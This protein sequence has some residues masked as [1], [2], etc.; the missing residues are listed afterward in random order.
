MSTLWEMATTIREEKSVRFARP[1]PA[2]NGQAAVV[3]LDE[4]SR[5]DYWCRLLGTTPWRLC[6]A[7]DHVG[8]DPTAIRRFLGK[9]PTPNP[10]RAVLRTA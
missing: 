8:T 7:I 6:C 10:V 2:R 5:L 4:P 9:Q 1:A 3:D